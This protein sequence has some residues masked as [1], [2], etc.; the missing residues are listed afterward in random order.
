MQRIG[1]RENIADI[2][3]DCLGLFFLVERERTFYAGVVDI[4]LAV[5]G[6]R[7][8]IHPDRD[9]VRTPEQFPRERVLRAA[10][11]EKP[12]ESGDPV[13]GD[14]RDMRAD[15]QK[16]LEIAPDVVVAQGDLVPVVEVVVVGKP[17]L[18]LVD[19]FTGIRTQ[20]ARLRLLAIDRD[21]RERQG[22]GIFPRR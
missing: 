22:A 14:K 21:V 2:N 16:R 20:I 19:I 8:D 1:Q 7:I 3:A 13:V 10:T 6:L 17:E 5:I 4:A 12:I 11:E 15:R 9:L 18:L